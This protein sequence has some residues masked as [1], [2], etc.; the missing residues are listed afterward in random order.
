MDENI[1]TCEV[2]Q[3]MH[4]RQGIRIQVDLFEMFDIEYSS[5]A[6]CDLTMSFNK[7]HAV[8]Y[9]PSYHFT[10]HFIQ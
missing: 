8:V 10:Y 3:K 6:I 9:L 1:T 5:M 4:W 7:N 2:V